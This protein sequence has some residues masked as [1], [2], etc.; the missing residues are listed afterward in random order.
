MRGEKIGKEQR[1]FT[2]IVLDVCS[3]L[4]GE[5]RYRDATG[6][7]ETTISE[8]ARCGTMVCS[9]LFSRLLLLFCS[10]PRC[11]RCPVLMSLVFGFEYNNVKK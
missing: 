11:S 3:L 7:G 5:S 2:I 8:I 9:Q 6:G 1:A 10:F 4:F